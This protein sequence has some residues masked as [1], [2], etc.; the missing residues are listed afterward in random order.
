MKNYE[1]HRKMRGEDNEL[2]IMSILTFENQGCRVALVYPVE[3]VKGLYSES[4]GKMVRIELID[5]ITGNAEI[6]FS[7]SSKVTIQRSQ[8]MGAKDS[9][10]WA[11]D[12]NDYLKHHFAPYESTSKLRNDVSRFYT[13]NCGGFFA[14]PAEAREPEK[15]GESR[16]LT[17]N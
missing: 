7:E 3:L 16:P 4:K 12:G 15:C 17:F 8:L 13:A 5:P 6:T 10:L 14:F 2:K 1:L 9:G 11:L